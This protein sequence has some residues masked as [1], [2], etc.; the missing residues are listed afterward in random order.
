MN[1]LLN[2]ARQRS[3]NINTSQIISQKRRG[4]DAAKPH[5]PETEPDEDTRMRKEKRKKT[6]V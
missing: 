2:S 5:C 4:K 1:S 6:S 3:T